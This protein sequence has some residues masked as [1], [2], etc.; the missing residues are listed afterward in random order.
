MSSLYECQTFLNESNGFF[1]K[2]PFDEILLVAVQ[3]KF[4]LLGNK[5]KI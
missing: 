2:K 1:I 4:V 5:R 3:N